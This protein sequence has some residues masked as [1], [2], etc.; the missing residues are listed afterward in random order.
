MP[1]MAALT[2]LF[3][4][5]LFP[6]YGRLWHRLCKNS[7][8]AFLMVRTVTWFLVLRSRL[9]WISCEVAVWS[10][11]QWLLRA[12]ISFYT[13]WAHCCLMSI[14]TVWRDSFSTRSE[15]G[16]R[17]LR[18]ASPFLCWSEELFIRIEQ[19]LTLWVPKTHAAHRRCVVPRY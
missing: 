1:R 19:Q 6:A 10:S 16:V 8:P 15:N 11:I 17:A 14:L 5:Q 7:E 3:S 9:R 2:I 12:R 18:R 13:L 4:L